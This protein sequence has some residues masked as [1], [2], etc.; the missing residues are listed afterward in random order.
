VVQKLGAPSRIEETEYDFDY[1]IYNNDYRRLLFVAVGNEKVVG[2]YTDSLDFD[3]MGI[4]SGSDLKAVG[5]VF[6]QNLTMSEI[7]QQETDDYTV[8]VLM[9]TLE[10]QKVTGIYVLSK[11][12]QTDVYTKEAMKNTELLVY[13]L[14]NSIR[15]RNGIPVLSW[16]SSAAI[17]SRKHSIDMAANHF[18]GHTNPNRDPRAIV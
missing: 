5:K 10:S 14:V 7:L 16:S 8:R 12:V 11:S 18:F 13:D 4:H 6:S 2:Y 3:Y 15:L 1:Y 17:A 9:D